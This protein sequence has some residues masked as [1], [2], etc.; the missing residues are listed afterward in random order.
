[1]RRREGAPGPACILYFTS[2]IRP[3]CEIQKNEG[4]LFLRLRE[5]ELEEELNIEETVGDIYVKRCSRR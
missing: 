1:M 5:Y 3:K 2:G 4:M